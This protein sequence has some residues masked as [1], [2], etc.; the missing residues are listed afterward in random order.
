MPRGKLSR[1]TGTE[2]GNNDPSKSTPISTVFGKTAPKGRHAK[3]QAKPAAAPVIKMPPLREGFSRL[4]MKADSRALEEPNKAKREIIHKTHGAVS[5]EA[6]V[7]AT[8]YAVEFDADLHPQDEAT[9]DLGKGSSVPPTTSAKQRSMRRRPMNPQISQQEE[10]ALDPNPNHLDAHDPNVARDPVCG[11]LVDKR[12]AADTLAP[13][14]GSGDAMLYFSSPECKATF[15]ED[16][17]R[18]GYNW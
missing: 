14:A 18:Y 3:G 2:L 11:I 9:A 7:S 5:H 10:A 15:E 4:P 6:K 17:S 8:T 12:T 1:E 13:P 16:P